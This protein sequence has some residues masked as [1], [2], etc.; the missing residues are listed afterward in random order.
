[1]KSDRDNEPVIPARPTNMSEELMADE[2]S[3]TK[4]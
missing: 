3:L 4:R 1:M 2:L